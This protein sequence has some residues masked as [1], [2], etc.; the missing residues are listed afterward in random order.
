MSSDNFCPT[1]RPG[2]YPS[3]CE[4]TR[5]LLERARTRTED[6]DRTPAW[7][8]ALLKARHVEMLLL[9]VDGVLTDGTLTY[10]HDGGENKRF[11]TQDGFGLRLMRE[12]GLRIG[13]ITART[14]A[15]V[16]R[17]AA[18]LGI[19]HVFQGS[20]Q[21][22][23]IYQEILKTISL[24]PPQTAYMGDD[25][26]DLPVLRR[27]G[28]SCAPANAVDEV[29][30]RVD[31]VTLRPGGYGAVREICDLILEARGERKELLRRYSQ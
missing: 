19:E 8:A 16:S 5:N 3:D 18:D 26:L 29:R 24:H 11:H 31:Y 25:W 20:G 27:A 14:S 15:A 13:L 1:S 17:R 28:F 23:E 30:Q 6:P 22:L 2:E 9:D 10:T 4:I 12:A 21:K 7:R